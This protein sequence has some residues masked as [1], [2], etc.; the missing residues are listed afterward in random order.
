MIFT[1]STSN[2]VNLQVIAE[3]TREIVER[4]EFEAARKALETQTMAED[5][6]KDLGIFFEYLHHIKSSQWVESFQMKQCQP[7]WKQKLV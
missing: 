6:Q 5:A 4:E 2:F 1:N 7:F 3:E